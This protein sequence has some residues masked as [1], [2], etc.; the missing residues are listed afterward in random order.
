MNDRSA[1]YREFFAKYVAGNANP[2]IANAFALVPR[3]R[4]AGP[5]PW[6]IRC[7]D[8]YIRTPDDDPAFIYQDVLI[9]LDPDRGINIGMPSAHAAWLDKMDLREGDRV[10][11]VG[12]GTGYYTAVIAEI[13]GASGTVTAFEIDEDLA[14]RARQ[15]LKDYSQVLVHTGSGIGRE[16]PKANAIYVCAAATAPS[17]AWIDALLPGGRLM[18]P[19]APEFGL[20]GMLR[21]TRPQAGDRWPATFVSRARFIGCTGLHGDPEDRE[22]LINAFTEG[23]DRVRSLRFDDRTDRTCWFAGDGWW[24]STAEPA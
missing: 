8:G 14:A 7:G 11:Q 21:V 16:L 10:I 9:G 6:S 3:E 15:N 22:R 5:G 19:L 2:G 12:A 13:V 24:L 18:F 20:G 1:K 4:F 17:W 23:W